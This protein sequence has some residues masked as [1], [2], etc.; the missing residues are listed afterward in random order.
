MASSWASSERFRY[1][2]AIWR[3]AGLSAA[4]AMTRVLRVAADER[5]ERV[6]HRQQRVQHAEVF[7]VVVTGRSVEDRFAPLGQMAAEQFRGDVVDLVQVVLHDEFSGSERDG[8]DAKRARLSWSGRCVRA[9]C[10]RS[11]CEWRQKQR[12]FG[13]TSLEQARQFPAAGAVPA[14]ELVG[15]GREVAAVQAAQQRRLAKIAEP[16]VVAEAHERRKLV[17]VERHVYEIADAALEVREVVAEQLVGVRLRDDEPRRDIGARVSVSDRQHAYHVGVRDQAQSFV[18]LDECETGGIGFHEGSSLNVS[19]AGSGWIKRDRARERRR[20]R[21]RLHER[22]ARRDRRR[23]I[24]EDRL[25]RRGPR[26]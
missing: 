4:S 17:R 10:E 15:G 21:R 7:V 5:L 13:L 22:D 20:W 23:A 14:W 12:L 26:R 16:E 18:M 1:C 2:S 19:M 11:A 6:A 25:D 9:G 8:T 3:S 24:A